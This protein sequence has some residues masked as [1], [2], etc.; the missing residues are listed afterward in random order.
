MAAAALVALLLAGCN[1][2]SPSRAD[3]ESDVRETRDRVD[4]EL[5]YITQAQSREGLINRM[6]RAA[7]EI[8]E[9]ADDL[10][11]AGAPEEFTDEADELV[12]HFKQLS[13]DID[14][15]ADQ[16]GQPEFAQT[17]L[18]ARGF[19]FES[20]TKA[21]AVL[22]RLKRQGIDVEPLARH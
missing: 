1:V 21:N 2:G 8:D 16:L 7:N 20:W 13:V 19:S 17:L 18:G 12:K 15:T 5:A 10:D 22:N 4:D 9:A 6:H 14:G 11:D 3:F